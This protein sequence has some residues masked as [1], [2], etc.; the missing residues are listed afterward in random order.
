MAVSFIPW[1]LYRLVGPLAALD[2]FGAE[3]NLT[4][5]IE[6]ETRLVRV[7]YGQEI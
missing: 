2:T 6:I 4:P 1:L 5:L 7:Q 3:R